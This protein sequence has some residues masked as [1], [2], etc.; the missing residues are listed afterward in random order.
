[1]NIIVTGSLGHIGKPLTQ[2][3]VQRGHSVTVISSK[4]DRQGEIEALGAKAA[5]GSV[6]NYSFLLKTFTG[7]DIVYLM[8]PPADLTDKNYDIY[9]SVNEIAVA[10][11]QAVEQSGVKKVVHLSGI[12]AHTDKD[13]GFLKIHN[14]AETILRQLPGDVAIKFMRPVGFYHNLLANIDVIK[15]TS[16]G[17]LGGLLALQH[18]GIRGLL[19]GHRG[20]IMGNYG[21]D[22][23]YLLVAAEDIAAAIGEEMERPFEGRTVRYIASEE[24]TCN[25]IARILG[26]AIGKPYL[27]HG[28]I[29]DKMLENTLLKSGMNEQ[30]A[31]GI[32]EM[33]VACRTGK[34]FEDYYI[35]R[36]ILGKTKLKEYAAEFA[37]NYLQN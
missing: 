13:I 31:H 6:S 7:A 10:Y 23:K 33:G 17:F 30:M 2:M 21:G 22:V 28:K 29:S 19:A 15:S 1:M 14:M 4:A 34:V 24:L 5:I 20:M 37:G 8:E 35:N 9:R 18:Y 32:V 11:K 26:E 36:P 25:E 12:G 27:K 16:K 3:L